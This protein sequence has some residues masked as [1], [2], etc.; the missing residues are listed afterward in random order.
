MPAIEDLPGHSDLLIAGPLTDSEAPEALAQL[1]EKLDVSVAAIEA[2][3]PRTGF[4]VRKAVAVVLVAAATLAVVLGAAAGTQAENVDRSKVAQ[5]ELSQDIE[6]LYLKQCPLCVAEGFRECECGW[7]SQIGACDN[8]DHKCCWHCCCNH[9]D[10]WNDGQGWQNAP[11]VDRWYAQGYDCNA[12]YT[13][14]QAEWS[15]SKAQWCCLH[16]GKGCS[17]YTPMEVDQYNCDAGYANWQGGW[18][19]QKK[20]WCCLHT[21]TGCESE[22]SDYA[23]GYDCSAGHLRN[24]NYQWGWSLRKRAW[25]C[26]HEGVACNKAWYQHVGGVFTGNPWALAM[27][28]ILPC[29][30]LGYIYRIYYQRRQDEIRRY[31]EAR[32]YDDG[33]DAGCLGTRRAYCAPC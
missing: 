2:E 25:C 29:L 15:P 4:P 16:E 14:W 5:E 33:Y 30:V 18:S 19:E 6:G 17:S 27:T 11:A 12:A 8:Y 32:A 28:L 13:T 7:A 21:G 22:H 23:T 24:M 20:A 31:W 3:Q 10:T 1:Q 26:A 9:E